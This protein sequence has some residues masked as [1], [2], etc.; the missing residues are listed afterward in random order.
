MSS[1]IFSSLFIAVADVPVAMQKIM[2]KGDEA[3]SVIFIVNL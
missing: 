2:F 1:C 3:V